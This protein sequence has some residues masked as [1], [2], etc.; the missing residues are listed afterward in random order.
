MWKP[1]AVAAACL[2]LQACAIVGSD[3]PLFFAAD[4]AAAPALRPGLWAMPESDCKDFDPAQPADK[5]PQCAN[6]IVVKPTT[7]GGNE[8]QDDGSI[9]KRELSYVLAGGDPRILQLTAPADKKPDEPN[10]LFMAVKPMKSD[11]QGRLI[12][13]QV[14][15]VLCE[16][17]PNP[18]NP[19]AKHKAEPMPGMKVLPDDKGCLAERPAA[20]RAAAEST[21]KWLK[22]EDIGDAVIVVHW[23]RDGDH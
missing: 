8:K 5:W 7:I 10:Y 22:D 3:K 11:E 4:A 1:L 2:S 20:V 18:G 9:K 16:P 12:Q 13:G 23:V 14:W 19:L 17:P 6:L 15:L 21:A